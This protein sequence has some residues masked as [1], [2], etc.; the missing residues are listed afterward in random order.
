MREELPEFDINRIVEIDKDPLKRES[1][2]GCVLL[3]ASDVENL[4]TKMLKDMFQRSSQLSRRE[5][6]NI[7]DYTGPLGTFASKIY[8]SKAIGVID[9]KLHGDIQKIRS[10]RNMAA[11]DDESFSLSN[12]KVKQIVESMHFDHNKT[13][14]LPRYSLQ[15]EEDDSEIDP[16]V[17]ETLLK[18]YGILRVDKIN[19]ILTVREIKLELSMFRSLAARTGEMV[20]YFREKEIVKIREFIKNQRDEI[21]NRDPEENSNSESKEG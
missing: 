20:R 6:K 10:I 7:F 15:H 17:S 13:G 9:D 18:G 12:E 14:R 21:E 3:L 2:R 11:H 19:F 16:T 4:L 5:E 1:D 8:L